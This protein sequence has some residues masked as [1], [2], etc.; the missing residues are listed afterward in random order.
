[1]SYSLAFILCRVNKGQLL[2]LKAVK[3]NSIPSSK[4][5][6]EIIFQ[7]Q[8]Q[9]LP[10]I[11]YTIAILHILF[12]TF[13]HSLRIYYSLP[14]YILL[15]LYWILLLMIMVTWDFK[16]RRYSRTCYSHTFFIT[17]LS[18]LNSSLSIVIVIVLLAFLLHWPCS[19]FYFAYHCIIIYH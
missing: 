1:M 2:S 17:S 8:F 7:I 6:I 4:V 19:I 9:H 10:G 11:N 14:D 13:M 15:Y 3:V 16:S 18:H 5:E 12:A